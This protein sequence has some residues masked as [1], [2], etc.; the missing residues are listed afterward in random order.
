MRNE[1]WRRDLRENGA[2][3][4]FRY[5]QKGSMGDIQTSNGGLLRMVGWFLF[6][7]VFF[8]DGAV[9]CG[10]PLQIQSTTVIAPISLVPFLAFPEAPI[11]RSN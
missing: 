3:E 10:M 7:F 5:V 9:T 8:L 6:F 1:I 2:F 4:E 11:I